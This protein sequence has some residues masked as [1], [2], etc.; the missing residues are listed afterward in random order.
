MGD[1]P[2]KQTRNPGGDSFGELNFRYSREHRLENAPESVRWLA[3]R[4]GAKRTGLIGSLL[5]TRA[6]RLL[7]FTIIALA[8]AFNLAPL[9]SGHRDSGKLG[10]DRYSAKAFWFDGRVLVSLSR[11]G[12]IVPEADRRALDVSA[13]IEGGAS[14]R[15]RFIVGLSATED[16]RLALESGGGKP[17]LLALRL[18]D[19]SAALDLVLPVQ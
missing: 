3:S 5:A 11:S 12:P 16:F 7:F 10:E 6:S 14:A 2:E 4:Y 13:A 15:A 8:V 1:K 18:S 17:E 9:F 19:G